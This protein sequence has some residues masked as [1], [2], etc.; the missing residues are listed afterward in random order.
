MTAGPIQRALNLLVLSGIKMRTW[1][2][3]LNDLGLAFKLYWCAYAVC[4]FSALTEAAWL[5]ISKLDL[6]CSKYSTADL[7]RTGMSSTSRHHVSFNTD[8]GPR[9]IL[10]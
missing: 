7:L 8:R 2:P 3:S 4:A 1:S 10:P 9:P 6:S 5:I